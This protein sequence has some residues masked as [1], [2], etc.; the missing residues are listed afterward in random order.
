MEKVSLDIH[1]V[2]ELMG[3]CQKFLS[4]TQVPQRVQRKRSYEKMHSM[5]LR[6]YHSILSTT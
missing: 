6:C 4:F 3:N 2:V 5:E 1:R